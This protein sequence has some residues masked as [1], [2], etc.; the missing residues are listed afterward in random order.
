[1][2]Q[3]DKLNSAMGHLKNIASNLTA[4]IFKSQR[5]TRRNTQDSSFYRISSHHYDIY[6]NIKNEAVKKLVYGER[7]P[8]TYSRGRDAVSDVIWGIKLRGV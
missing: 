4:S 7:F 6:P 5:S 2:L 3:T 8:Y 1:M